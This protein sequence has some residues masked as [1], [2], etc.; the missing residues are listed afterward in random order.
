[1]SNCPYKHKYQLVNWA[2][3]YFGWSRTTTQQL[4]KQQLYAIWYKTQKGRSQM[5]HR[6][7]LYVR[8]H[9]KTPFWKKW[10]MK[11]SSWYEYNVAW[12]QP[13]WVVYDLA[14]KKEILP[15]GV[16]RNQASNHRDRLEDLR[17]N[18]VL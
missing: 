2:V 3:E 13:I 15:G 7:T 16:T 4:S 14:N 6:M 8:L 17:R 18:L 12:K 9:N 11:R 10:L 5:A 1:M